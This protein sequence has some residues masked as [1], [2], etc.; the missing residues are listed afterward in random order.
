MAQQPEAQ[1]DGRE[2]HYFT[3]RQIEKAW[4][5][6]PES[7]ELPRYGGHMRMPTC[8]SEDGI[9]DQL[10]HLV[11][12]VRDLDRSE[13][14]YRDFFGMDVLGRDL[15]AE[16]QPHSVLRMNTGQLLI[17]VQQEKVVP[18][19]PGTNGVHH[20]F[21]MTPNQ[22]RRMLGRVKERGYEIGVYRAELLAMG[23]YTMNFNDPDGHHVEINCTGPEASMLILPEAGVIDCGAADSYKVGDVKLFK[24]YDF[25]VV[26]L[27]EGF[28]AMSRWCRHMNGR[29]IYER[30]HWRFRCPY[31]RATYDRRGNCIGGQPDLNALW[32]HPVSISGAGRV[33]VNTDEAIDRTH[34]EA[35]QA[36]RWEA[37]VGV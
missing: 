17:L 19:R 7:D 4:E 29:V 22:Y 31:H 25:F 21:T 10:S 2:R 11:L 12:G 35:D 30:D 23:E 36:M 18:E 37:A 34:F 16:Q 5:M 27:K 3:K 6:P 32:L 26:R 20:A 15:T 1:Q 8:A 9:A 24:E 28:I 14:W 33:L 13:A